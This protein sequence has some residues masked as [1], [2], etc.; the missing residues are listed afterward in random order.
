MFIGGAVAELDEVRLEHDR[1]A[2]DVGLDQTKA[3]QEQGLEVAFVAL[4]AEHGGDR[5]PGLGKSA[6]SNGS[7]P[8]A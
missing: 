8:P 5:P 6:R 1:P 3:V 7:G 2:S 4:G